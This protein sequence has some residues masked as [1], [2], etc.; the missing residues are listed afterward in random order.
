MVADFASIPR[1]RLGL[2]GPSLFI[3]TYEELERFCERASSSPVLAVDTEFLRERTYRPRLCLIQLA[4]S[5]DDIAAA[6]NSLP[7]ASALA[8]P[9]GPQALAKA[10]ELARALPA[11]SE[12]RPV[13]MSGSLYLLSEFFALHSQG[14]TQGST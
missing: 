1:L 14:L 5:A 13:L 9:Q 6:C 2:R 3:S 7:P 8:L 11:V 12:A 4:T 10:L